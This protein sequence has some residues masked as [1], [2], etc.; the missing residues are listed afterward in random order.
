MYQGR[1]QDFPK[2]GLK[3]GEGKEMQ[4]GSVEGSTPL[5]PPLD[6]P[7]C[8]VDAPSASIFRGFFI[9]NF[10]FVVVLSVIVYLVTL[11]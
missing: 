2:G 4:D 6:P 3:N 11:P 7:Q 10:G 5:S 1:I 8:I 9:V